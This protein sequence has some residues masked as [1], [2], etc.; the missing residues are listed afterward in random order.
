VRLGER[1]A[2][3]GNEDGFAH[4]GSAGDE[5]IRRLRTGGTAPARR[6]P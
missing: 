2:C 3:G 4:H 6:R 5:G 1:R